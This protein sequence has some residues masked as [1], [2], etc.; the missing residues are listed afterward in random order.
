MTEVHKE[1]MT[2]YRVDGIFINRWAGSGLCYC[3]HCRDDFRAATGHELPRTEEPRDP[4]RRAYTL[5][6]QRRLFELWRLWDAEVR[7][8][9]PGSC[10]IPNTGGGTASP[11]DMKTIGE[12]A[13]TLFTDRQARSGPIPP[14]VIGKNAKEYRAAMG[15]KPVGGIFSVGVEEAYRWKDSV[16][17]EAEIR[18]WVADGVAN[19]LRP[20]FTKFSGTLYDRRWLP[21]V[22]DLCRWHRRVEGYL[23]HRT[24]MARVGLVYSQQTAWYYGG[25]RA[26]E[27]VEDHALGWY[28]AL[29]EARIPFEMVHDR[30]LDPDRVARL[31]TLILPNVAALSDDQCR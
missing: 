4:A 2:R 27:S 18:I 28:Q 12:L 5:W 7:R 15:P 8:I 17:G 30:L 13:P 25:P 6:Q 31:K 3:E 9:Q 11:L 23:R 1:I 10:V 21:V 22:E 20:W 19:G 14:W 16:Q 26:R 29:V 24:P